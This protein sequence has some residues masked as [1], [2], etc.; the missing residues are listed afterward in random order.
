MGN[1]KILVIDAW[2]SNEEKYQWEDVDY[3]CLCQFHSRVQ[4]H[5]MRIMMSLGVGHLLFEKELQIA[6]IDIAR[7]KVIVCNEVGRWPNQFVS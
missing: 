7:Y 1:R 3:I 6:G 5:F 2:A 4:K